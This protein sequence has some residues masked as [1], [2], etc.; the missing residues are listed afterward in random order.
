MAQVMEEDELFDIV[1]LMSHLGN[2][3]DPPQQRLASKLCICATD[4]LKD[5][6]KAFVSEHIDTPLLRCDGCD[7]T[8][9]STMKIHRTQFLGRRLIRKGRDSGEYICG[10]MFLQIPNGECRVVFTEA[11][12]LKDK[13]AW[14]HFTYMRQV[15]PLLRQ[16]GHTGLEVLF[17]HADRGVFGAYD[18]HERQFQKAFFFATTPLGERRRI[19]G[20]ENMGGVAPMYPPR[21]HERDVLGMRTIRIRQEHP[22]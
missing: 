20:I 22:S 17:R 4:F 7:A 11:T 18:R 6:A 14:T 13:A 2:C 1:S 5:E 12:R 9:L 19:D 8:P 16:L 15:F 10:R 21:C 3:L